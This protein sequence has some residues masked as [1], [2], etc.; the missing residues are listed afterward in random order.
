M[1]QIKEDG[2]MNK[3]TAKT[4]L[5]VMGV[6][7]TAAGCS[8]TAGKHGIAKTWA[9]KFREY[10]ILP[11][12]PPREDFQVGDIVLTCEVYDKKDDNESAQKPWGIPGFHSDKGKSD[13]KSSN[14]QDE[15]EWLPLSLVVARLNVNTELDK[16]Y[17]TSVAMPIDSAGAEGEP[18]TSKKK[19]SLPQSDTLF[20]GNVKLKTLKN[21]AFPDFAAVTVTGGDLSAALPSGIV[22]SRFGFSKKDVDNVSISVP[23]AVSYQLPLQAL[24][25]VIDAG[26]EKSMKVELENKRAALQK[27]SK[28]YGKENCRR[29]GDKAQLVLVSEVYAAYAI[30][31]EIGTKKALDSKL[32]GQVVYGPDDARRKLVDSSGMLKKSGGAAQANEEAT[33]EGSGKGQ[34]EAQTWEQAVNLVQD[35]EFPGVQV[36]SYMSSTSSIKMDR[37]FA[38]P[39]VI[40]YKGFKL[41]FDDC[42]KLILVALNLTGPTMPLGKDKPSAKE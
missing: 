19:P 37:R 31:T 10:Q 21:V 14:E 16:F 42:G 23:S 33:P 18:D 13:N 39:V 28:S 40:G 3:M 24:E 25:D 26:G 36:R 4:L 9:D 27:L 20:S 29:Y 12:F 1:L 15:K 41:D 34:Q 5:M 11:V 7:L 22:M 8:T 6:S 35:I 17:K 2:K 32:A 38:S 30:T